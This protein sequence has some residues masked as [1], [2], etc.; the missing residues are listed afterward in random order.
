LFNQQKEHAMKKLSPLLLLIPAAAIV[1]ALL[2]GIESATGLLQISAA[3]SLA[4]PHWYY[5][6]VGAISGAALALR[7]CFRYDLTAVKCA[8][9]AVAGAA[10]MSALFTVADH[11]RVWAWVG[12]LSAAPAALFGAA[13]FGGITAIALGVVALESACKFKA[14]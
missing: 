14:R 4:Y 9:V 11:A 7:F 6:L 8:V 1:G 5:T 2:M 12:D 13:L 3:R 10:A